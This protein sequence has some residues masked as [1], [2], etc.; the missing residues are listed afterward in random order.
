MGIKDHPHIH[1]EHVTVISV[2]GLTLG[3]PPYTWGALLR[4]VHSLLIPRITPIYMGSTEIAGFYHIPLEDHPH[5]HG[6]HPTARI[7]SCRV[8]GSPPYTWGALT[9]P[10]FGE[11]F[12][13]ITP[14]YM[15]STGY[16]QRDLRQDGDHPHIHGEHV[17]KAFHS[18]LVKGS[19]PYTW[20]A[21]TADQVQAG[22]LKDHPHIHGE[23][24]KRSL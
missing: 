2:V 16:R 1:G 18:S 11:G 13:R 24:I 5:I 14:I 3:S 20:G 15:G 12:F 7:L 9:R 4:I 23:H 10:F 6:E 8:T 17:N 22:T 19:P 21:L